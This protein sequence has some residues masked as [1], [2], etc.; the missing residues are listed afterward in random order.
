MILAIDCGSTNHKVALFDAGL[1][2]LADCALP[3]EYTVHDE[4]A[5][6]FDPE[7]IWR[8]TLELINK[9]CAMASVK[10][11]QISAIAIAG[12]AQTFTLLDNTGRP[13]IPFISWMDKRADA[14]LRELAERMGND[15]HRH[16]SFPAPMPQLQLSKL[17]W[18]KHNRPEWLSN[19]A[20]V[21]SLPGFLA[22][23]LAG[24]NAIDDNLAAMTGVYSLALRDWRPA[25]LEICGLTGAQMGR[26]TPT[27]AAVPAK[28]RC[29]E[30][31]F[32]REFEVVFSGNDQTAGAYAAAGKENAVLTLGT[33]LA[34]CRYAGASPGPFHARTC[35]GP[36]PGGGYYELAT[37]DEGCAALD[38]AI[39]RIMPG[40]RSGFLAAAES[41]A[42]GSA[43]FYPERI[44]SSDAWIGANDP[45]A[46]A[47]AV[48]EGICFSVRQPMEEELRIPFRGVP[49]SIAG[50][51]SANS[52]WLQMFADVCNCPII[53]SE[54]DV[55]LGAAMIARKCARPAALETGMPILPTPRLA[56]DYAGIYKGWLANK[57]DS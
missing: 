22:H 40:N 3:V 37:R 32:A 52:F 28:P 24:L 36:Y 33:A 47:R 45:A 17:L 30:I 57:R 13:L 10:P 39:D 19:A 14:E 20:S 35:W 48:L 46:R 25:A 56:E 8:D 16:C 2:R 29:V 34:V 18:I 31:E 21:V 6:E 15:F 1:R 42:P 9:T 43:F 51:G 55:L 27:G 50:G 23:G 38:W 11:P 5:V 44:R 53:R 41:A 26:L 12:Q 7:N 4:H 54:N 49:L